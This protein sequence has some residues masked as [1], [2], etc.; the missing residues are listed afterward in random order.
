MVPELVVQNT[1]RPFPFPFPAESLSTDPPADEVVNN[2]LAALRAAVTLPPNPAIAGLAKKTLAEIARIQGAATLADISDF[3]AQ[4]FR[5]RLEDFQSKSRQQR[6]AFARQI[7]MYLCRKITESSFPTIGEHFGRD[8]S[9][10]I[11]A[12]NLIGRRV[13]S[14]LPFRR[15]IERI[16][17]ELAVSAVA[18]TMAAAA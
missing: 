2:L 10:V 15:T 3:V 13:E 4:R 12:F 11:H 7:A 6:I 14:D 8:H 16:E 17:H 5:L 18:T 1:D 9:T